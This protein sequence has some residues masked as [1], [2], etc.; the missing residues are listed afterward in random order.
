MGGPFRYQTNE[1]AEKEGFREGADGGEEPQANGEPKIKFTF[2]KP[3]EILAMRF[4]P[5]DLVLANGYLEKDR[6]QPFAAWAD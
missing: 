4:D 3:L 1:Q 5:G 2:R 6:P